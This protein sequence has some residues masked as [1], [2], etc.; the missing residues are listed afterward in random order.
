M[1]IKA[2]ALRGVEGPVHA[3]AIDLACRRVWKKTVPD[4]IGLFRQGNS[5]RL[6]FRFRRIEQTQLNFRGELGEDS[7]VHAV[8]V[9]C[10]AQRRCSARPDTPPLHTSGL[11]S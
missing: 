2:M 6:S 7:E 11:I 10:S 8:S 9:E 1:L 5:T 4:V 3:I